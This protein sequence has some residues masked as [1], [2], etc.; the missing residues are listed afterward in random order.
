MPSTSDSTLPPEFGPTAQLLLSPQSIISSARCHVSSA[1]WKDYRRAQD[2]IEVIK[3]ETR[4]SQPSLS[5][6][7]SVDT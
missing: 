4:Y 3:A 2:E 5:P 6:H 7:P 1:T